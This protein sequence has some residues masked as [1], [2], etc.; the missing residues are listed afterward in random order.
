MSNSEWKISKPWQQQREVFSVSGPPYATELTL[1]SS[2]LLVSQLESGNRDRRQFGKKKVP[3]LKNLNW[4]KCF[5]ESLKT[6]VFYPDIIS[7]WAERIPFLPWKCLHS[8]RRVTIVL[9]SNINGEVVITRKY[10]YFKP[11]ISFVCKCQWP[12]SE[13]LSLCKKKKENLASIILFAHLIISIWELW[14][15]FTESTSRKIKL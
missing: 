2:E 15:P 12:V 13:N 11:F 5:G 3:N 6:V 10:S 14:M 7:K 4:K 8:V 1:S 9:L